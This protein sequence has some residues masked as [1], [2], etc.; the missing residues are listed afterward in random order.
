MTNKSTKGKVYL[1]GAGPGD[2]ELITIKA[3]RILGIAD[4][5]LTDRLVSQEIIA[6]YVSSNAEVINVGKQNKKLCSTRQTDI[7][8]ML[9]DF[10]LAGKIVVRLKG[11]DIAFF[12]NILDELEALQKNGIDF[13]IVPGITAASGASAYAGIPLTA[14]GFTQSVR[15]L[16]FHH[17]EL[18]DSFNWHELAQT[19]DTL[20]FY[21]GSQKVDLIVDKLVA[22]NIDPEKKIAV[23]EQAT[24]IMQ[25]VNVYDIYNCSEEVKNKNFASPSIV[26]IGKVIALHEKFKWF[27]ENSSSEQE[28]YFKPL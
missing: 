6:T 18:I 25:K 15:F 1:I 4:V 21:M 7:N 13:E 24:T 16:T 2:P 26:L 3:T 22:N 11:G 20:V 17:V 23:I 5:I 10:A 12:S 14:R 9:V 27:D 8:Q 19:E 28:L